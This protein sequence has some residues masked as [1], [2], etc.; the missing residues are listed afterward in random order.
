M[1]RNVFVSYSRHQGGWV[2]DRLVP[3]L[4]A[5]GAGVIIDFEVFPAGRPVVQSMDEWQDRADVN[6]LV[7]SPQYLASPFCVHE[8]NR[9]VARDPAFAA[10]VVVP[11]MRVECPLPD[12]IRV[13]NPLFVDL[14]DDQDP[15]Q[16]DLLLRAC[17]AS[18]GVSAPYWLEV[19]DQVRCS[20]F[21]R[22]RSVNLQ[23][24]GDVPWR[25]LVRNV[26]EHAGANGLPDLGEVDL[27]DPATY[28]R[29]GLVQE[30]FNAIKAPVTAP[31]KPEDLVELGKVL[32]GRGLTRLALTHF[33]CAADRRD[34]GK[35]LFR[36]LRH[37]VMQRRELV[38]LIQSRTPF[39]DLLPKNDPG[40][41]LYL[42]TT[43]MRG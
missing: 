4:R 42:E 41:V 32:K 9:A 31:K 24:F 30:I 18:L 35:E 6:L 33:D 5:G 39:G 19:R 14:R 27:E 12:P 2:R 3:A 29:R 26:R 38:L 37:W 17:G 15:K 28:S 11:V 1:S 16:W 36:A 7:L 40:S 13:P 8:M 23:V 34:Y 22:N 21:E 25:P 10:G 20:L 43:E